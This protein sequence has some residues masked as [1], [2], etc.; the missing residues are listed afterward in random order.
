MK[1]SISLGKNVFFMIQLYA[2]F[3]ELNMEYTCIKQMC[4]N[5]NKTSKTKIL[6]LEDTVKRLPIFPSPAWM[7]L[8]KLSLLFYSACEN[9]SGKMRAH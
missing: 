7:S 2:H 4:I 6:Q 9:R 8:T 1:H 3:T 5:D